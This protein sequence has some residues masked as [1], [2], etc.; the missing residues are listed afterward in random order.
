MTAFDNSEFEKYKVEAK[1]K[2]YKTDAYKEHEK[3]TRNYPKQKWK[4]L[5]E[6][7]DH[8]MAEFALCMKKNECP[9]SAEAQNLVKMTSISTRMVLLDLSVK[10]LKCIVNR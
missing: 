1:E 10:R 2:W 6:G 5:A 8:I 9:D 3:K 4:E 7:M